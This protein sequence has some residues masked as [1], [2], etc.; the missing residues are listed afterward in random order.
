LL[1]RHEAHGLAIAGD[2]LNFIGLTIAMH[3][4]NRT[5]F[6]D[7]EAMLRERSRQDDGIMFLDQHL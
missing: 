2:E 6:A 4:D 5:D 1:E 3:E 7:L